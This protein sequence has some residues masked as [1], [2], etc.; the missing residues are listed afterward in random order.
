MTSRRTFLKAAGLIGLA[1][2]S[3]NADDTDPAGSRE[4]EASTPT[5][6]PTRPPDPGPESTPLP[7]VTPTETKCKS[8][9]WG[10]PFL[11]GHEVTHGDTSRPVVLMTYDDFTVEEPD[12]GKSNFDKILTAYN[13]RGCKTTFFLPGGYDAPDAIFQIA[14][15]VERIVAEGHTLGCH[16]VLHEPMTTYPD[17]LIRKNLAIWTDYMEIIVPGYEIRYFRAPFGDV[18]GRVRSIFAEY[19]MQS[20]LWSVESN[21]MVPETYSKV[22]GVVKPGDI[23]LSHSQRPYDASLAGDILD[24]LL[25]KGFSVESVDTGLA[26]EDYPYDPCKAG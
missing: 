6:P 13:D 11:A 17:W 18:D 12:F 1:A 20:V 3:R 8:G 5:A 7:S 23:V 21:G 24:G 2:C 14:S 4:P 26:P 25:A 16:G 15:T 22:A 19:G 10:N 9:R